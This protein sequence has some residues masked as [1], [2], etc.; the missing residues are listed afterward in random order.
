[1][2]TSIRSVAKEVKAMK[3]KKPKK[4]DDDVDEEEKVGI[5]EEDFPDFPNNCLSS[6][7]KR[8][9]ITDV[10]LPGI[11]VCTP[12]LNEVKY[13]K[14]ISVM[15]SF[16]TGIGCESPPG[17]MAI[18]QKGAADSLRVFFAVATDNTTDNK[19]RNKYLHWPVFETTFENV[20]GS[21]KRCGGQGDVLAGILGTFFAW[22]APW[23]KRLI[24]PSKRASPRCASRAST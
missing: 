6:G 9:K 8:E 24:L 14:D 2:A 12:N 11:V 4:D 22:S 21:K 13:V 15:H 19:N 17:V 20:E 1:M 18:L 10:P 3:K 23:L 7:G 16:Y 5:F